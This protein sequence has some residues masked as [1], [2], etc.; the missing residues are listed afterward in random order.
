MFILEVESTPEYLVQQQVIADP[1][2]VCVSRLNGGV[3]NQVLLV[4]FADQNRA[5]WVIKQAR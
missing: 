3:S 1:S 4:E 2:E 5:N